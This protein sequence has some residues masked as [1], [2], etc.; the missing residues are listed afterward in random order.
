[1]LDEPKQKPIAPQDP[2]SDK[3]TKKDETPPSTPPPEKRDWKPI[4]FSHGTIKTGIF[5]DLK[6][7]KYGI[8]KE[9]KR[10]LNTILNTDQR[11]I[12]ASELGKLRKGGLGARETRR[13]LDELVK[14]GVI[15][16]FE[17][18][19]IKRDFRAYR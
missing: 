15:D 13:K 19:R 12:V 14:K 3:Q 7:F 6:A 16:K 5:G 9:L 4:D 18:K 10:D 2:E 8:K 1:M 11:E 17:A